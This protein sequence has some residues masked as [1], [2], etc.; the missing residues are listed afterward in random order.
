LW[1]AR[2]GYSGDYEVGP[3]RRGGQLRAPAERA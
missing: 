1:V 3:P 2:I